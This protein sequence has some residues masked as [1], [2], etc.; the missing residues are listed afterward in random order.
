MNLPLSISDEDQSL[1]KVQMEELFC[2]EINSCILENHKSATGIFSIYLI[3]KGTGMHRIDEVDFTFAPNQV[4]LTFPNQTD[5][6][7][8]NIQEDIQVYIVEIPQEIFESFVCYLMYPTA[9]YSK[10]PVIKFDNKFFYR[11]LHEIKNMHYEMKT[12][13]VFWDIIYS[14]LRLVHFMIG[15]GS[16]ELFCINNKKN[17]SRVLIRFLVLILRNVR[18]ERTVS[19]YADKLAIS[20]NYLNILCKRYFN[21]RAIKIINNELMM[22]LRNS[23]VLSNKTVKEIAY[24]FNFKDLPTFSNFFKMNSG[25]NPT[26]FTRI[27]KKK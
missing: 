22:E 20:P 9:F 25:M 4:H 15:K 24:D 19:F 1:E 7:K 5:E 21:K 10:N 14:R 16:S 23:L 18:M 26:E 2:S 27:N 11:L 17:I 6:W 3:E 13:R 8:I 12:N